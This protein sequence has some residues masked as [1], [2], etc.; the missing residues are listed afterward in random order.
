MSTTETK[1]EESTI[2]TELRNY[3]KKT[4]DAFTK[5]GLDLPYEVRVNKMFVDKFLSMAKEDKGPILKIIKT[6]KRIPI[7][8]RDNETGKAIRKDYL[9]INSELHAKKWTGDDLPPPPEYI[10]GY[11]Y[12]PII[13]TTTG[14]RNPD[15]GDFSMKKVHQGNKQ[16]HDIELTVQNRKKI[17]EE[18]IN[19]A[20]GTHIDEIKFYY[21]IQESNKGP[22]FRCANYTYDQFINASPEEMESLAR[23]E[24]GPQGNIPRPNKDNKNYHG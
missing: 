8:I 2:N 16:I 17:I 20:T 5:A 1:T 4:V 12:E 19:N 15:T 6:M 21:Q 10:E 13:I 3:H 11:H 23:K 14:D 24:G 18:I 9:E 22:A 7:I